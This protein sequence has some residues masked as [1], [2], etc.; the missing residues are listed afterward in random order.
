ML[1][2]AKLDQPVQPSF[3]RMIVHLSEE[4]KKF[5]SKAV[6]TDLEQD[7][8]T[9]FGFEFNFSGPMEFINRYLRVLGYDK[10]DQVKIICEQLCRFQLNYST[11]LKYKP[12]QLAA[13]IAIIS[14][15]ILKKTEID[16]LKKNNAN[17]S[18]DRSG[19]SSLKQRMKF[20]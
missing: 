4:D 2:A 20:F 13:A 10:N 16:S 18:G 1:L 15:N 8:I 7:I 11:F 14:I 6:L 5:V 9:R 12:S 19:S 3:A 17:G